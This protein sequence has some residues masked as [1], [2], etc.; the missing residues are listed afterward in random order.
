M[1]LGEIKKIFKNKRLF[2]Q[3][4]THRSWLN[5]NGKS[6]ESNERLE[7]LG[8]AV[9]E[10]VVSSYLYHLLPDKEEGF[11]TTLRAN[12]VNTENLS[13]FAERLDLGDE[14]FLSKGEEAGGGRKNKSLLADTVEALLGAI[15]IDSGLATTRNFIEE[16]LLSDIN[17]I[18]LRPLKDAK[19]SLQEIIQ[20]QGLPAPVYEVVLESGPDHDKNFLVSVNV[21]GKS[22][23]TGEGKSKSQAEQVAAEHALVKFNHKS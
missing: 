7:F 6:R 3:A 19:S 15:Y 22:I 23:A 11:L 18:L 10:F 5:E 16:Q 13:K 12:L 20:A 14:L 9:L 2:D 17:E 8:D 4:M 21:K 1:N